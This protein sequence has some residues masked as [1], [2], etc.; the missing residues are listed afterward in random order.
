[1]RFGL[2]Y[3]LRNPR[4]WLVPFNR[5]YREFLDQ[6]ERVEALGYDSLWV[7]EHHY[8]GDDGW[9]PAGLTLTAAVA[10]RTKRMRLGSWI[11]ALPLHDPVRVAEQIT[12]LDYISNGRI[13]LGVAL[14]YR[15]QEFRIH[16]MDRA[17]RGPRLD[18]GL[19]VIRKCWTEETF[20][21]KG[22]FNNLTDMQFYPK[23]IQIP[24][25][26][27]YMGAQTPGAIRRA[28]RL[29]CHLLPLG[30]L[31]A[32]EIY[33]DALRRYGRDPN[34]YEVHTL[35]SMQ[36]PI[37]TADPDATWAK[38]KERILYRLEWYD[39]WYNEAADL[40]K[41][42][43]ARMANLETQRERARQSVMTSEQ[44]RNMVGE[45]LRKV[46]CTEIV[47]WGC[48]PGVPLEVSYEWVELFATEVMPHFQNA[49]GHY[50]GTG[51]H[52][53]KK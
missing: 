20:S 27:I 7:S 50:S 3:D 29:G 43:L 16:G 34:E 33:T 10:A 28:A 5:L 23:P 6:T 51:A 37:V 15:V 12:V 31:N 13:R 1:M 52:L 22:R 47:L 30:G 45:F 25:P 17:E 48:Y 40:P 9:I 49:I 46:P 38:W 36:S 41:E 24:H 32:Y 44:C 4:Q 11:I 21:F 8:S 39:R 14:G 2:A 19:E 35:I 18:E 42:Q 26:P 53:V